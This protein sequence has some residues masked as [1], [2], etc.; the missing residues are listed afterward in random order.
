MIDS[1]TYK[2]LMQAVEPLG[3][4]FDDT[5]GEFFDEFC[6]GDVFTIDDAD[7]VGLMTN[8]YGVKISYAFKYDLSTRTATIQV[9]NALCENEEVQN[10][11]LNLFNKYK[12]AGMTFS[13]VPSKEF[14]IGTVDYPDCD[15][16][17]IYNVIEDFKKN[18]VRDAVLFDFFSV[19]GKDYR[20]DCDFVINGDD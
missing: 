9:F 4:G 11:M 8:D 6:S 12:P 17:S 19:I 7:C 2:K 18:F 15:T 5:D 14:I 1:E 20:K 16:D 13:I 3:L 10:D